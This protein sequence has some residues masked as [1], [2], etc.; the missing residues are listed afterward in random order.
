LNIV[1][2]DEVQ[3][4][5]KVK[6]PEVAVANPEPEFNKDKLEVGDTF[7]TIKRDPTWEF[8]LELVT[9]REA[10]VFATVL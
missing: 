9:V 1:A 6:P 3:F 2:A 10:P 8:P 7:T 4:L 5:N